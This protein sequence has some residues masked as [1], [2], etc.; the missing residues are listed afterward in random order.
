MDTK[1]VFNGKQFKDTQSLKSEIKQLD[2]EE[3]TFSGS[4]VFN[5][6]LEMIVFDTVKYSDIKYYINEFNKISKNSEVKFEFQTNDEK[7]GRV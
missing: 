7:A 6:G 2:P 1:I 5:K 3:L 4:L